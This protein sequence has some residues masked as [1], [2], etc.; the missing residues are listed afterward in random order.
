M[1]A[2][3]RELLARGEHVTMG[4]FVGHL[5]EPASRA[6]LEALDLL[7][8]LEKT[9][10]RAFAEIAIGKGDAVLESLVMAAERHGMWDAVLQME[11]NIRQDSRERFVAFVEERHRELAPR[12]NSPLRGGS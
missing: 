1:A 7:G 10:Q 12:L 11:S 6:A 3:T 9:Q 4:R 8:H 5:S 2:I